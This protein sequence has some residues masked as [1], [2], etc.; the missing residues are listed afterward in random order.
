MTRLL[1]GLVLL[2]MSVTLVG[3]GAGDR[4]AS[5]RAAA[6]PGASGSKSALA[7]MQFYIDPNGNGSQAVA[8][9]RVTDKGDQA[10]MVAKRIASQPTAVWL[11]TDSDAVFMQ[12]RTITQ[13]ATEQGKVPVLVAYNLPARDCGLYSSGGASNIDTYLHW[14]GSFAAG[15]GNRKAVVILEPDA[16][17]HS[18][19]GCSGSK[20]AAERYRLLREAVKI[21]KRQP[22]VR[23]YLDA[24][25]AS[26]IEDLDALAHALGA[27]GVADADGFA[28]NVSNF[29]T[30]K[31]STRYGTRLSQRLDGAH[32]V[33][34]TSRNGA[35]PPPPAS[36]PTSHA[37][38]CNPSGV[39]L[40]T[41]PTTETGRPSVDAYLWVK[42]PGDSDGACGNGA[43]AAGKWWNAYASE[44]MEGTKQ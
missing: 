1:V 5:D 18:L 29:E 11:T 26:W 14:L 35:G 7:G 38:W 8:T 33:I 37:N 43:P 44:L 10:R 4:V 17:A 22:E 27:S 3:C 31:R 15:I 9:L 36:D 28:L 41:P 42:Q 39:R 34:D 30:T 6:E 21:L 25:N 13:A 20:S 19:E 16:I 40:G 12:A 2:A 32:F 23:V 24:G